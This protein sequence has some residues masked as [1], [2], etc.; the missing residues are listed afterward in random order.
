MP[1]TKYIKGNLLDHDGPIAHG[2]NCRGKMNSGVAKAISEKYLSIY[3][4]YAD[5]IDLIRR[6][7]WYVESPLGFID[8]HVDYDYDQTII[9]M[10]T[11]N[12]YGHDGE[13]YVSYSAIRSCFSSVNDYRKKI[14]GNAILGIPKIGAGLGGGDWGIIEKIINDVT[15]DI[16]I[17]VYEL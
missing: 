16:E 3:T 13:R 2:V 10:F 6:H 9:N 11:Q 1:I 8:V 7:V 5:F 12:D 4:S 15:P 17:W 14:L